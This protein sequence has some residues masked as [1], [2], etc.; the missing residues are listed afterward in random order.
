[1]SY[2]N[3]TKDDHFEIDFLKLD[4]YMKNRN[5]SAEKL[6]EAIN[7]SRNW[8]Y[9]LKTEESNLERKAAI[10]DLSA[11]TQISQ[12]LHCTIQDLRAYSV[13]PACDK[14]I[15]STSHPE[16][17]TDTP[18]KDFR[19]PFWVDYDER[20]RS[21]C[22]LI[23][24][25][26][27]EDRTVLVDFLFYSLSS[28]DD[29]TKNCLKTFMLQC[30][31]SPGDLART[32]YKYGSKWWI[33]LFLSELGKAMGQ[34]DNKRD[35]N[36]S[37]KIHIP[38]ETELRRTYQK[39]LQKGPD[40]CTTSASKK[41]GQDALTQ[42]LTSAVRRIIDFTLEDADVL[43]YIVKKCAEYLSNHFL[44]SDSTDGKTVAMYKNGY[45]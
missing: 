43:E 5:V 11:A 33:S 21:V 13:P 38:T 20:M 22:E 1:M 9:S 37:K 34:S 7:K 28:S 35:P 31:H 41:A 36:I 12:Y 45:F 10:I 2:S 17:K 25:M 26:P 40:N 3:Q 6:S 15:L 14:N 32:D 19:E 23:E 18:I 4:C 29:K 44:Y 16:T 27:D 8:L 39:H 24:K 42:Q 30:L